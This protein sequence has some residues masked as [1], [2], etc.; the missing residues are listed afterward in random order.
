MKVEHSAQNRSSLGTTVSVQDF[1]YNIPVRRQRILEVLEMNKIRQLIECMALI[2]PFYS[3]SVFDDSRGA[4][5]FSAPMCKSVVSNFS[6]FYGSEKASHL[7]LVCATHNQFKV[8]GYI[9]VECHHNTSLQFVYI[10]GR[11]VESALFHTSISKTLYRSL[12]DSCKPSQSSSCGSNKHGVYVVNVHCSK[13][14]YDITPGS[15]GSVVEFFDWSGVMTAL[16]LMLEKFLNDYC[17]ASEVVDTLTVERIP[18][19]KGSFISCRMVNPHSISCDNAKYCSRIRTSVS[20]VRGQKT[21][22]CSDDDLRHTDTPSVVC[23]NHQCYSG[24]DVTSLNNPACAV[25]SSSLG[26]AAF[27]SSPVEYIPSMSNLP[28]CES[29]RQEENPVP[30]KSLCVNESSV[31]KR[32]FESSNKQ[33]LYVHSQSGRCSYTVPALASKHVDIVNDQKHMYNDSKFLSLGWS[34]DD[35]SS[36]LRASNCSVAGLNRENSQEVSSKRPRLVV[37]SSNPHHEHKRLWRERGASSSAGGNT[38]LSLASICSSVYS[39][40]SQNDARLAQTH[41][42]DTKIFGD[43]LSQHVSTSAVA[44]ISTRWNNPTFKVGETVSVVVESQNV[45]HVTRMLHAKSKTVH[46]CQYVPV[47][48]MLQYPTKCMLCACFM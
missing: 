15:S 20:T 37:C 34:G 21:R 35:K 30:S 1:M 27:T 39:S 28:E 43:V 9:S 11:I 6:R 12:F 2:H 33:V 16:K 19:H 10:N 46:A 31:W 40:N 36:Q 25:L 23:L 48:C 32:R 7:K 4:C 22:C 44:Q 26:A 45:V 18:L 14:E 17:C 8:Q 42:T 3:F 5:I 29:E 24:T 13:N 47:C 41:F 38:V